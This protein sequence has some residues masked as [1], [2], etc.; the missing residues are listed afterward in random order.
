M[1]VASFLFLKKSTPRRHTR[2]RGRGSWG[3]G[4]NE[5]MA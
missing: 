3:L 2:E 5:L 1:V 4:G